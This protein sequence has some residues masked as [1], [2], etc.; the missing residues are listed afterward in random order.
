MTL[1]RGAEA[2]AIKITGLIQNLDTSTDGSYIVYAVP[3]TG[4]DAWT[5][6]VRS[7]TGGG[8]I[9]LFSIVVNGS[10]VSGSGV[11]TLTEIPAHQPVKFEFVNPDYIKVKSGE[12]VYKFDSTTR[13]PGDEYYFRI[14]GDIADQGN[15][16]YLGDDEEITVT[17]FRESGNITFS[18]M[19]AGFPQVFTFPNYIVYAIKSLPANGGDWDLVA[20]PSRIS[21]SQA[22]NYAEVVRLYEMET[23]STTTFDLTFVTT[24]VS[25][26]VV[27]NGDVEKKLLTGDSVPQGHHVYDV[28]SRPGVDF[29]LDQRIEDISDTSPVT[30]TLYR[31]NVPAIEITGLIQNLDTSTDGTYVVYAVPGADAW[32]L[33]IHANNP[34]GGALSLFSIIVSNSG[35]T[36]ARHGVTDL[37]EIPPH[38]PAQYRYTNPDL[39]VKEGEFVYKT[40]PNSITSG[41]EYYF[42]TSGDI[43]SQSGGEYFG[44]DEEI[45]VTLFRESG[46]ITITGMI[47][48]FP[49][50]FETFIPSYN[51][52]ALKALPVNG[53]EWSLEIFIGP[54]ERFSDDYA[55]IV[56]L[57]EMKPLSTTTFELTSITSR[58]S[59]GVVDLGDVEKQQIS[60]PQETETY[61]IHLADVSPPTIR[62]ARPADLGV[63]D[64]LPTDYTVTGGSFTPNDDD[65]ADTRAS[66]EFYAR[67]NNSGQTAADPTPVTTNTATQA[68]IR[69]GTTEEIELSG[70]YGTFYLMR[71]AGGVVKWR[72]VLN[73]NDGNTNAL[74]PGDRGTDQ[75][76]VITRDSTGL[77]SAVETINITVH[78]RNA[79][80]TI[81]SAPGDLVVTDD[82]GDTTATGTFT[83]TDAHPDH[84]SE[85]LNFFARTNDRG[86]TAADPV[87]VTTNTAT[88]ASIPAGTDSDSE[89]RLSGHY[90][91]FFL[92]RND[93]GVVTWRY[94]LNEND[95]NTNALAHG[96]SGT[97]QLKVIA[98]DALGAISDSNIETITVTVRG[99]NN[100]PVLSPL[101]TPRTTVTDGDDTGEMASADRNGSF[102]GRFVATDLDRD[103]NN[104]PDT[105]IFRVTLTGATYPG[106]MRIN[107]V[108][109][110]D[111][112]VGTY[113]TLF[114]NRNT[115]TTADAD[116]G[117]YLFV[118]DEDVIDALTASQR[119]QMTFEVSAW[120]QTASTNSFSTTQNLTFTI[121]GANDAPTEIMLSGLTFGGD[122]SL[123][124]TLTAL[125][126]DNTIGFRYTITGLDR[127]SF[128]VRGTNNDELHFIGTSG[129]K[130]SYEIVISVADSG[131]RTIAVAQTFTI[132]E[133]SGFYLDADPSDAAGRRYSGYQDADGNGLLAENRDGTDTSMPRLTVTTADD[134]VDLGFLGAAGGSGTV[135]IAHA[136]NSDVNNF[137]IN[138]DGRL[139]YIGD[140]S[141]DFEAGDS[142]TF[143]VGFKPGT[144]KVPASTT[145]PS[146]HFLYRI[147]PDTT[148]ADDEYYVL[149][150]RDPT[151]ITDQ[152]PFITTI[153]PAGGARAFQVEGVPLFFDLNTANQTNYIWA[154]INQNGDWSYGKTTSS[155][156]LTGYTLLYAVRTG[157]QPDSSLAGYTPPTI[158]TSV[159]R[160]AES[161]PATQIPS[162]LPPFIKWVRGSNFFITEEA[163]DSTVP[164]GHFL[165][166]RFTHDSKRLFILSDK[167]F[168]TLD[169]TEVLNLTLHL[170]PSSGPVEAFEIEGQVTGLDLSR[171]GTQYYVW[172]YKT[173][174]TG[175]SLIALTDFSGTPP[176]GTEFYQLFTFRTSPQPDKSA[177]GYVAPNVIAA[178][179]LDTT[180]PV[181]FPAQFRYYNP[182]I[183]VDTDEFVY[184]V[185]PD[186]TASS[187]DEYYFR[188]LHDIGA[189]GST[190]TR[191]GATTNVTVIL[192]REVDAISIT[193]RIANLSANG[194]G[195]DVHNVW[196]VKSNVGVWSLLATTGSD[197]TPPTGYTEPPVY[198]YSLVDTSGSA[199]VTSGAARQAAGT[200]IDIGD[201]QKQQILEGATS[202]TIHLSDV[203]GPVFTSVPTGR[204]LDN[205]TQHSH[206]FRVGQV[207]ATPPAG[208]T[209]LYSITDVIALDVTGDEA[210]LSRSGFDLK[211]AF[212]IGSDGQIRINY[213]ENIVTL[214]TGHLPIRKFVITVEASNIPRGEDT[215]T[216]EFTVPLR[217]F[218]R[219]DAVFAI[220]STG[221]KA[222]P[223]AGDV[224]TVDI[225][226]TSTNGYNGRDPEG[227]TEVGYTPSY[228]W[229]NI[230]V[231]IFGNEIATEIAGAT[232]QTFTL[233]SS[234]LGDGKNVIVRVTYDE[235]SFRND[236]VSG[237]ALPTGT[238]TVE[239]RL[240]ANSASEITVPTKVIP[241]AGSSTAGPQTLWGVADAE[242]ING[243]ADNDTL[244]SG[245]GNDIII[246]GYGADTINLTSGSAPAI[247]YRFE[248]DGNASANGN[249]QATDGGDTIGTM[250]RNGF[251]YDNHKLV[252]IDTAETGSPVSS[253]AGFTADGDKPVVEVGVAGGG[254]LQVKFIF[255]TAGTKDGIAGSV[256]AGDTLTINFAFSTTDRFDFTSNAGK[257]TNLNK[258]VSFPGLSDQL[259]VY[260]LVDFS[261]L[262]DLFGGEDNFYVIQESH[263]PDGLL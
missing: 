100:Q 227:S 236:F 116:A 159:G 158:L 27:D 93:A 244:N 134:P 144:V 62:S 219:G 206:G 192:L 184:Q 188:T 145:I 162:H 182:D 179:T 26:G 132:T 204:T 200:I 220:S 88:Q 49:D 71:D 118:P 230:E 167:D 94:V 250:L 57:Y 109:Y 199:Y 150:S 77:S 185:D 18:S 101:A 138:A 137:M 112:V 81:V 186:E 196:A 29:M 225:D 69:A 237:Q 221:N 210:T 197:R 41:D 128:T 105:L 123:V 65:A 80:P 30:M 102:S 96:A 55:E 17:L 135:A 19:I 153:F 5:L 173:A 245:G 106:G 107:N 24:R 142:L 73:P 85:S 97:D 251:D 229:Y 125:D 43:T 155:F 84:T 248:S 211:T 83:P 226:T 126:P 47:D 113:G 59:A 75:L 28:T 218:D 21:E 76:K 111:S 58:V 67:T 46:N 224:L 114:Y 246:G 177:A 51:I 79:P 209:V 23:L 235:D 239:A 115:D 130:D 20:S 193:G 261:I 253:L 222:S 39:R 208:T 108:T 14:S 33:Q 215:A 7:G 32:T 259:A 1:Y 136:D 48:G 25:A 223:A 131:G 66:L 119:P 165:Y 140:D 44:D 156:V 175:W 6:Q 70:H 203:E 256:A 110:T 176:S 63:T 181:H 3:G 263:V 152:T 242:V 252:L 170:A 243:G 241:A 169:G 187:G 260:Q 213:P 217:V 35:T 257:F 45:T 127:A 133:D 129:A 68:S 161:A 141:G 147:D 89:V 78:G 180:L 205:D 255:D 148:T 82:G 171:A 172:A 234:D 233:K 12:F 15:G 9:S 194:S 103:A 86:Q 31:P 8:S 60:T 42:K 195:G 124:G 198:L 61:T 143:E 52:Y 191:P 38:I 4:G 54:A 216:A 53:G 160:N 174:T 258:T 228:Q 74:N 22:R 56:R 240:L 254:V 202:Y 149:L 201:I 249:W 90:G 99:A 120:D 189:G 166:N 164:D 178:G 11:S 157:S 92:T 2:E 72:Y 207:E 98:Q 95:S 50:A 212:S 168:T 139:I 231:S 34:G 121:Q 146:G 154:R 214:T 262:D 91:N 16:E 122:S 163:V 183:T 247:L 87:V 13:T 37:T 64:D 232:G 40:D 10:T 104:N 117:R 190:G 36:Q 151:T 238:E